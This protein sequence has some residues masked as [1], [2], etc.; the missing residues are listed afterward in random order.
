M[1][2]RLIMLIFLIAILTYGCSRFQGNIEIEKSEA[3]EVEDES[4]K[5]EMI[6]NNLGIEKLDPLN[7]V[8]I[9]DDNHF[10]IHNYDKSMSKV[11]IIQNK[12]KEDVDNGNMNIIRIKTKTN[13]LE[14]I[15]ELNKLGIEEAYVYQEDI[16][17]ATTLRRNSEFPWFVNYTLGSRS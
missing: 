6:D 11:Y 3:I 2:N 14:T 12:K 16:E 15:D 9:L 17:I 13:Y 5:T 1:K 4:T 8:W 7:E 10:V